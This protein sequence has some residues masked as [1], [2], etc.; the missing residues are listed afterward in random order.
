MNMI[1]AVDNNW[2]IGWQN[3]LLVRIP[4]DQKQFR[5]INNMSDQNKSVLRFLVLISIPTSYQAVENI[6]L[7]DMHNLFL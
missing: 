3:S 1:A 5:E 7:L 4:R 6:H 2:A